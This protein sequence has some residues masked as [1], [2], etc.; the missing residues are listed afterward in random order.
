M[1]RATGAQVAVV[2]DGTVHILPITMG[3]HYGSEVE[4]LKGLEENDALVV[5]P[6]DNILE[7]VAVRVAPPAAAK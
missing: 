2:K 6:N 7:G 3:R 5:N 1:I 4:V